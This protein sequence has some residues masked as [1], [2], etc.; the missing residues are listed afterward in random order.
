M[1]DGFVE[2]LEGRTV[3]VTGATGFVGGRL[4]ERLILDHHADVRALVRRYSGAAR[5]ARFDI[6]MPN[7]A[8]EDADAFERAVSGADVVFNLAYV[9]S[10]DVDENVAAIDH[11]IDSCLRHG[12]SRLVQVS[13]YTVHEPFPDGDLD[14]DSPTN[15]QTSRYAAAKIA[16]ERRV[17]E[18]VRSRGLQAVI[19]RPTIVYGPFGGYWIDRCVEDLR[20]GNVV[21]PDDGSGLCNGVFIDDL[22][23]AMF[24]AATQPNIAGEAF[25]ISG[26]EPVTW[27]TFYEAIEDSIGIKALRFQP[28]TQPD[29]RI[30][31]ATAALRRT[32]AD[33]KQ[34]VRRVVSPR[35]LGRAKEALPEQVKRP[36]RSAYGRYKK[37]APRQ[38][39]DEFDYASTAHCRIDKARKLLGYDPRYD[40]ESGMALTRAYLEWAYPREVR[41]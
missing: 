24:L 36:L 14:A 22:V 39:S 2:S 29:D 8:I 19:L 20:A 18:A 23:D 1:S 28:T 9:M 30:G 7:G 25:L 21:L 4:V 27:K 40:F 34:L 31:G 33:P 35:M 32:L 12:V 37:I 17:V 11:V 6:A 15:P 41:P 5:I 10:N 13:S 26:P 16:V 3:L 38:I